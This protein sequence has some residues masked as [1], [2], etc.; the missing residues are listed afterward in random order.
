V[1][2]VILALTS[3][4]SAGYYLSVVGAMFLRPRPDQAPTVRVPALAGGVVLVCAATLLALGLYPSPLI[5]LARRA[6]VATEQGASA[7]GA[8]SVPPAAGWRAAAAR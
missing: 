8:P 5:T 7:K 6:T 3:F 2:A 1:L 4:V